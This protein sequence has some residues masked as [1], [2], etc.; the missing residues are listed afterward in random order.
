MLNEKINKQELLADE[1]KKLFSL[2]EKLKQL[3]VAFKE[4]EEM[5]VSGCDEDIRTLK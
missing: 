3:A 1:Q 4:T 2:K 5:F